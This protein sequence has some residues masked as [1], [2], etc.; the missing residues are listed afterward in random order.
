MSYTEANI[1]PPI[2]ETTD[3]DTG[4]DTVPPAVNYEQ[5]DKA[6]LGRIQRAG[7]EAIIDV[8]DN[9]K[10][11]VTSI[12]HKT[13]DIAE[14]V[15][16]RMRDMNTEK[17]RK[18]VLPIVGAGIMAAAGGIL[19]LKNRANHKQQPLP[20]NTLDKAKEILHEMDKKITFQSPIV[21]QK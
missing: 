11:R 8:R 16:E 10:D 9:I 12:S 7:K 18:R 13:E 20:K 21:R 15:S 5:Q 3:I 19:I 14:D 1:T 4:H 17:T 6:L 2:A